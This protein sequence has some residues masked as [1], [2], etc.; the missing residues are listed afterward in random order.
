MGGASRWPRTR[1]DEAEVAVD[2]EMLGKV[3][4]NLIADDERKAQGTI[5]TPRPVVQFMCREALVPYLQRTAA[6]T[7]R[8]P[9][10]CSRRTIRFAARWRRRRHRGGRAG[11][12][13]SAALPSDIRVLDPAVGSG[14]FLLGMLAE[15]LR[16]R[17]LAHAVTQGSEPSDDELHAWKLH[18][19]EHGLFGVDIQ[20]AADRRRNAA[21]RSAREQRRDRPGTSPKK[22]PENRPESLTSFRATNSRRARQRRSPC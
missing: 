21:S 1:A 15:V 12:R 17:R 4:E 3:F 19:I 2:P 11:R 10:L 9:A 16:L 22:S 18:A 5:Y 13:G 6:S 8:S 14:A 7:S 20:T